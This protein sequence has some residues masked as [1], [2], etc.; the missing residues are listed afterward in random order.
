MFIYMPCNVLL[1]QLLNPDKQVKDL[2][3]LKKTIEPNFL[4]KQ[5]LEKMSQFTSLLL[6]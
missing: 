5:K 1:L 6:M 3:S 2:A 4:C